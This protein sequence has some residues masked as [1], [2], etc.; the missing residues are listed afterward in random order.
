MPSQL[1][2]LI[3]HLVGFALWFGV[4]VA[5]EALGWWANH[6]QNK[7]DLQTFASII[8]WLSPRVFVPAS[9]LTLISGILLVKSSWI[10]HFQDLWIALALAG[11]ALT[12]LLAGT[13]IHKTT[14][15]LIESSKNKDNTQKLLFAKLRLFLRLDTTIVFLVFLDM[16]YKPR[17]LSSSYFALA[18]VVI[19]VVMTLALYDYTKSR[20]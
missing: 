16:L 17:A 6:Q 18:T 15:D 2:Y 12:M 10:F 14:K 11:V 1:I 7:K 9:L 8:S 19:V 5:L 3:F 20:K 4:G 13:L